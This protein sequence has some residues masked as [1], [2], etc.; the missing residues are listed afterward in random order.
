MSHDF[1][2]DV[3]TVEIWFLSEARRAAGTEG[4]EAEELKSPQ[5]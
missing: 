3:T 2:C 5:R 4:A 1:S